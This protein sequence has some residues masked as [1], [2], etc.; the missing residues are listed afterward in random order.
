MACRPTT[1]GRY[2]EFYQCDAD[3][4]GSKSL[5]LDAELVQIIQDVFSQ[6]NVS[7]TI[8]LNNRKILDSISEYIG[9]TERIYS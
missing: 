4:I 1:K 8:R 3:V 5:V 9:E 7:V 2:R 6:L